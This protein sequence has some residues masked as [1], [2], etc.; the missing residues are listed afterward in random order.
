MARRELKQKIEQLAAT[1]DVSLVEQTLNELL[2]QGEDVGGGIN[3]FRLICHLLGEPSLTGVE[4]V[5]ETHIS[6]TLLDYPDRWIRGTLRNSGSAT[7]PIEQYSAKIDPAMQDEAL[8]N[9]IDL[10]IEDLAKRLV[11]W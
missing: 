6:M 9:A 10:A 4:V 11:T 3:A 2:R 5:W 7:R 1:L 8:N